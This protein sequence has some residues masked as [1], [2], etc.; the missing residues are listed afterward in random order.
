MNS[1]PSGLSMVNL[2]NRQPPRQQRRRCE[3]RKPERNHVRRLLVGRV[4]LD[5]ELGR[6]HV[7]QVPGRVV[8][9]RT[10]LPEQPVTLAFHADHAAGPEE[11]S[12]RRCIP[13]TGATD[14]AQNAARGPGRL[15]GA[16]ASIQYVQVFVIVDA[17][18]SAQ[19]EFKL[20][21]VTV[22]QHRYSFGLFA[23]YSAKFVGRCF[24]KG[25]T[26]PAICAKESRTKSRAAEM[27]V[28]EAMN[29]FAKCYAGRIASSSMLV[30]CR[31]G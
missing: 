16:P 20:H 30:P 26:R 3:E 1:S 18:R 21:L 4:I 8:D 11:C 25:A 31:C 27:L 6:R 5:H 2:S 7:Q 22:A 9:S 15:R 24:L 28:A 17:G 29:T 13:K 12:Q 14:V 10:T 23:V 19:L